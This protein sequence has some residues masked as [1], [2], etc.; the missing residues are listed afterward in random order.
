MSDAGGLSAQ[1]GVESA[2]GL[3]EAFSMGANFVMHA[4]GS[5]HSFAAVSYEKF[6]LDMETIA[7]LQYYF[8]ALDCSDDALGFEALKSVV[9]EEE[10]FMFSEHT[11]RRCRLDPFF[12]TVSLHGRAL[13]EPNVAIYAS[14]RA[15]IEH[16]LAGYRTPPLDPAVERALDGHMRAL[17]M[18]ETDIQ[19]V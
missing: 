18:R 10:Q 3:F 15:A 14:C 6:M 1:A 8:S 7:R 9:T 5:L 4:A 19:K 17:G 13:G 12:N 16:R 11:L 2:L